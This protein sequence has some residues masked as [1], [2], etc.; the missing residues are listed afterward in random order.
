MRGSATYS[1]VHYTAQT[2]PRYFFYQKKE[3]SG[4][5][6][7]KVTRTK[8]GSVGAEGEYDIQKPTSEQLAIKKAEN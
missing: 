3:L 7:F 1:W 5:A 8:N 2:L 4:D 6:A